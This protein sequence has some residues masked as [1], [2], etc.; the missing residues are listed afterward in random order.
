MQ[1]DRI[2]IEKV[3]VNC[4]VGRMSQQPQFEEKLLPEIVK[5]IAAIT[6]QKPQLRAAKKSIA[7][8]KLRMGQTVGL[9][10]TLRGKRASDFV[11]RLVHAVL[12]RV[13]DFRGL[14]LSNVDRDGNLTLGIREHIVFPEISPE[15]TKVSF[16]F[17]VTIV[18]TLRDRDRA[19]EF[20]K[21]LGIPLQWQKHR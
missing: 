5:D 18:P 17:E 13:R 15:H 4:G 10:A 1:R 9:R 12:P 14:P 2:T 8:F 11:Q 7:G 21:T 20:Y 19:L 6:G 16:G 3:V